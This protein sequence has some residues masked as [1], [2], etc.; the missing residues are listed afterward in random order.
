MPLPDGGIA[1]PCGLLKKDAARCCG[2]GGGDG[3]GCGGA[4]EAAAAASS[5]AADAGGS[6]GANG[7]G[8]AGGAGVASGCAAPRGDRIC[9]WCPK[10]D[11]THTCPL[12]G[13]MATNEGRL[14]APS[15]ELP[16]LP[17][18]VPTKAQ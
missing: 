5:P 11:E 3:L 7:A 13:S 6:D 12:V 4:G 9:T 17:P 1:M 10:V 15:A 18:M 2:G 14:K 16:K 8:D